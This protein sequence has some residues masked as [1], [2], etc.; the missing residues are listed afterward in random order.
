LARAPRASMRCIS[1]AGRPIPGST[2]RVRLRREAG[3]GWSPATRPPRSPRRLSRAS[4]SRHPCFSGRAQCVARPRTGGARLEPLP[5]SSRD[6]GAKELGWSR[7]R[8]RAR[9][10]MAMDHL[11]KKTSSVAHLQ[12]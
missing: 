12:Q 10:E 11:P 7:R 1:P 9:A 2:K 5:F 4:L 6:V 8:P 3:Q